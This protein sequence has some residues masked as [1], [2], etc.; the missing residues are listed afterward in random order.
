MIIIVID[1]T[2]TRAKVRGAS[3]KA[4]KSTGRVAGKSFCVYQCP[5]VMSSGL[6]IR[7]SV[8]F[9]G[10]NVLINRE[11][12]NRTKFSLKMFSGRTIHCPMLDA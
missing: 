6:T 12:S 1:C 7:E 3:K 10:V 5:H 11:A 2:P 8:N 9:Y 4:E